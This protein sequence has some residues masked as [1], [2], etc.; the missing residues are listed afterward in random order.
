MRN[1]SA[2]MP[3]S[4]HGETVY[5][6]GYFLP[7][8]LMLILVPPKTFRAFSSPVGFMTSHDFEAFGLHPNLGPF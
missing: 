7:S 6:P 8:V 5:P 2:S 4:P 1:R 3:F